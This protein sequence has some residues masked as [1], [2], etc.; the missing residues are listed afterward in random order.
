MKA[1]PSA[2]SRLI[3]QVGIYAPRGP[4]VHPAR[5]R[6]AALLPRGAGRPDPRRG[7]HRGGLDGVVHRRRHRLLELRH[8]HDSVLH[9]LLD[10]RLPAHRRHGLGLR[11]FARQG[12]P[13]GRHRRAHHPCWAKAC[14]TRT[15]TPS[16]CRARCP[17]A[18]PTI[19]P[20]PTSSRS[21]LQDGIRRMYEE[22]E[23][24]STTSPCTTKTMPC[25]RCPRACSEGILRGHVQV[26]P[27]PK[28]ARPRRSSSAAV[29]S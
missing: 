11:R 18:S 3:R 24:S 26:R 19:P 25:P 12:F 28:A 16:A 17:P 15:A 10:V 27:A 14:S 23:T 29:R 20:S 5:R 13:D 1:A 4:E 21:S 7:H 22:D 2:S 8:A 9:V 6:H